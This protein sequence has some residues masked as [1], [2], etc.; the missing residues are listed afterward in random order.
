VVSTFEDFLASPG[1]HDRKI[2]LLFLDGNHH[3]K[4][5][6]QY[7][8]KLKS[9]FSANTIVLVDDIYW[10]TGYAARLAKTYRPA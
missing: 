4:A 5:L 10:S 3:S 8:E 7:Y 2:D 9:N 6:L 1:N